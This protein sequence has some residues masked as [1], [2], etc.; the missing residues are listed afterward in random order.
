[1][2]L[3]SVTLSADSRLHSYRRENI[4]FKLTPWPQSLSELY[5]PCD[6]RLSAKL[7][8]TFADRR[9]L[10]SQCGGSPRAVIS[11]FYTGAATFSFK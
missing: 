11:V 2:R 10:R 7:V 9:V 3:E 1:M 5:R 4:K 6:R 8:V